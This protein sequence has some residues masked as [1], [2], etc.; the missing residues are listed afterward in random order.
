MGFLS[1]FLGLTSLSS[2]G[3]VFSVPTQFEVEQN[4]SVSAPGLM[5]AQERSPIL[6][7][8]LLEKSGHCAKP[9]RD[10]GAPSSSRGSGT[11]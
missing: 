4:L 7:S 11:R 2:L 10:R 1:L 9:R 3:D 5:V 8:V 6:S